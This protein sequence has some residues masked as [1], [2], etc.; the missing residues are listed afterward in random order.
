MCAFLFQPAAS[1]SASAPDEVLAGERSTEQA[2]D[3][4]DDKTERHDPNAPEVRPPR[5]SFQR[6]QL[7]FMSKLCCAFTTLNSLEKS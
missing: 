1:L 3:S 7:S 4:R 5:P 6:V 2:T